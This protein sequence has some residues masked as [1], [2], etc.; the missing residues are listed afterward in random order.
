MAQEADEVENSELCD[1]AGRGDIAQVRAYIE[2]GALVNSRHCLGGCRH[3]PL[4]TAAVNGHFEIVELLVQ[5]GADLSLKDDGGR[6]VFQKVSDPKMQA[7]LQSCE[8][9][10]H[11]ERVI[12]YSPIGELIRED[13]YDFQMRERVTMI[14]KGKYGAVESTTI[15]GFSAIE[16]Q[17][18]E[19]MLRKAFNEHVKRGGKVEEASIFPHLLPK[20]R[21]PLGPH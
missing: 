6:T 13:V 5:M 3:T 2:A 15:T 11:P 10:R 16:D 1:L 21:L 17:S 8:T 4:M 14:R 9:S 20:R 7:F 12:F 19:S 18:D